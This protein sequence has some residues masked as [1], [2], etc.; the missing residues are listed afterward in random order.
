[1]GPPICPVSSCRSHG[2]TNQIPHRRWS[3][4]HRYRY[5][6]TH[7][8]DRK[9][10]RQNDLAINV[11]GWD[12]GVI[13]HHVSKQPE[14]MPRT[15]LLLIQKAGKFH[16]TWIKDLNRLLHDQNKN[17]RKKHF[18]DRCLHGY[19]REDLLEAHRPECKGI[20]QTAVRVEM[21]Q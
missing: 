4:L 13:V 7:F 3:R 15:N 18:C 19:S 11:F 6:H 10:E 14:D 8:S 21:P 12:K 9:V 2:Q 17:G 1:M 5:P 20:G 16:Y